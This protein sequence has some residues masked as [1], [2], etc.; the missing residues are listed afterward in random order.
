MLRFFR[1]LRQKM[2]SENKVTRYLAYAVGEIVLVVIGILIAL[3]INTWNEDRKEA[4]LARQYLEGIR[5]NLTQDLILLDSVMALYAN[6][7][8]LINSVEPVFNDPVYEPERY[9]GLFGQPD[10]SKTRSLFYRGVSFRPIKASYASLLADGKSGILGNRELFAIIQEIYDE[11]HE[12]IASVYETL[13]PSEDRIHWNYPEEKRN[14]HYS[15]LQASKGKRIFL[16][17]ANFVEIE[18]FYCQHLYDLRQRIRNT[19]EGIDKELGP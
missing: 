17:L 3:Q 5:D 14:W 2:L 6:D 16:D 1:N 13:K 7:I 12:R 11:R 9:S 4:R 19:I 18:Y 8:Q 15:D 10:T